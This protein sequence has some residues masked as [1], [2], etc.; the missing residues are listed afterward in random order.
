MHL[1]KKRVT[2][3]TKAC[4]IRVLGIG[5]CQEVLFYCTHTQLTGQLGSAFQLSPTCQVA[6]FPCAE[7]LWRIVLPAGVLSAVC[8]AAIG[9]ARFG[10]ALGY[11]GLVP[12]TIWTGSRVCTTRT[13]TS[14]ASRNRWPLFDAYILATT[15]STVSVGLVARASTH[16]HHGVVASCICRVQRLED[17]LPTVIPVVLY[18]CCVLPSQTLLHA[19]TTVVILSCY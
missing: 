18:C 8:V 1:E 2:R 19:S 12:K 11:Q 17:T 15:S 7:I 13:S 10:P 14:S 3:C 5:Y 4:F 6:Q 9:T 16:F